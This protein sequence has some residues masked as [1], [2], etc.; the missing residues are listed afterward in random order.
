MG[1]ARDLVEI[2]D[3]SKPAIEDGH[4]DID[5]VAVPELVLALR[6]A[7]RSTEADRMLSIFAK[8]TYELPKGN[9]L[10]GSIRTMNEAIIAALSGHADEG[11][12]KIDELSK[13]S[14]LSLNNVPLISLLNNPL[15]ASLRGDPRLAVADER[16]R[17]A[18]NSERS[19]A[20]LPPIARGAWIRTSR[21]LLTQ[22]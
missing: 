2:Y 8:N 3:L 18:L 11:I 17:V 10:G 5:T 14:P 7:G 19:K 15:L 16:L 9:G 12:R 20:G 6:Q 1:R 4:L 13:R 21:T 22:N